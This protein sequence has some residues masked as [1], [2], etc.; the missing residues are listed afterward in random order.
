[1]NPKKNLKEPLLTNKNP[2]TQIK[3]S[4][5]VGD[6]I[7]AILHSKYI[8]WLTRLI[9]GSNEPCLTCSQRIAALNTLFPIPFWRL[10]FKNKNDLVKC[11]NNELVEAGYDVDLK[12]DGSGVSA[13]KV[14]KNI[15]QKE[16]IIDSSKTNNS[17]QQKN[18]KN[19][20]YILVSSGDTLLGEFMIKTQVFKSI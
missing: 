19:T 5:G 17:D 16:E 18:P 9:T 2:A 13:S 14:V 6:I 12:E 8:G 4:R 7:A 20:N 3:Y 10:F 1:M 11:L 15:H